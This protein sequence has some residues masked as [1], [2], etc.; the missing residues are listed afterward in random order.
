MGEPAVEFSVSGAAMSQPRWAPV[1]SYSEFRSRLADPGQQS[2]TANHILRTADACVSAGM[3]TAVE[4]LR[5]LTDLP[6]D[7]FRR[8]V[9]SPSAMN[10]LNYMSSI[11]DS[12][13][14]QFGSRLSVDA[15]VNIRGAAADCRLAIYGLAAKW[16]I[17]GTN[18]QNPYTEERHESVVKGLKV[19]AQ[20]GSW[21]REEEQAT[22]ARNF[23]LSDLTVNITEAVK[24]VSRMVGQSSAELR[25]NFVKLER[26]R[27]KDLGHTAEE[28]LTELAC[29]LARG[30]RNINEDGD[31]ESLAQ[32]DTALAE[33]IELLGPR[34]HLSGR[35]AQ[36]AREIGIDPEDNIK[37]FPLS[38]GAAQRLAYREAAASAGVVAFS[39]SVDPSLERQVTSNFPQSRPA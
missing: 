20:A 39:P 16:V 34:E 9:S 27:I 26:A 30:S 33:Y 7:E 31:R 17:E 35:Y 11:V 18:P 3:F 25:V 38:R 36:A 2:Q 22:L 5:L 1:P 15:E 28:C 6:P 21:M 8:L 12:V 23:T 37:S 19:L 32:L 4:H 24:S 13:L 14:K 29:S 10:I